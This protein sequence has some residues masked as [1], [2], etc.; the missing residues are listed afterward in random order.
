[1]VRDP[2]N[3]LRAAR[4]AQFDVSRPRRAVRDAHGVPA[5]AANRRLFDFVF[6]HC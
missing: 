6:A 1:M 5:D 3:H 4:P 2:R